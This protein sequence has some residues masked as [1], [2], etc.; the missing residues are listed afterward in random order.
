MYSKIKRLRRGGARV[1]DKEIAADP[2]LIGHVTV[3]MVEKVVHMSA[4]APM[5]QGR[6]TPILPTLY[7]AKLTSMHGDRM[8]VQGFE[9]VGNQEEPDAAVQKQEWAIQVMVEQPVEIATISHRPPT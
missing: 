4:H 2:G 5:G 6:P 1:S 3:Y 8:L 9:R 7:R